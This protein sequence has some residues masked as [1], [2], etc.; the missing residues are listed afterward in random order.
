LHI[1]GI[2][3]PWCLRLFVGKKIGRSLGSRKL[4]QVPTRE[5]GASF[6]NLVIVEARDREQHF[7]MAHSVETLQAPCNDPEQSFL[8]HA[9]LVRLASEGPQALDPSRAKP[10][11]VSEHDEA[12]LDA[13]GFVWR[14]K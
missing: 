9:V 13:R 8:E 12:P 7:G 2:D 14:V 1:G 5:L 11:L 3:C 6:G 4:R 10:R